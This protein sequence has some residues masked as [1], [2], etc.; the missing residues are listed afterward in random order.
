MTGGVGTTM[1]RVLL[2][3][4]AN[5]AQGLIGAAGCNGMCGRLSRCIN[6]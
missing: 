3:S 2:L 6:N 1:K 4:P 5:N